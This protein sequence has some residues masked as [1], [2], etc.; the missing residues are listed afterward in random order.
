MPGSAALLP[1][2]DA[3]HLLDSLTLTIAMIKIF[4]NIRVMM[5]MIMNIVPMMVM[6]IISLKDAG[7]V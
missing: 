6:M 4:M 5:V 1:F 3:C 7:L 2:K